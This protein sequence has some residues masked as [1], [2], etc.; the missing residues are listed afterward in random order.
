MPDQPAEKQRERAQPQPTDSWDC[1][2]SSN[3]LTLA[4]A[5]AGPEPDLGDDNARAGR[6][7]PT[8][9]PHEKSV[10]ATTLIA[11]ISKMIAETTAAGSTR[12]LG[13]IT[14]EN[15]FDASAKRCPLLFVSLSHVAKMR[16]GFAT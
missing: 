8:L 2:Q 12:S 1:Q 13:Q 3:L 5:Q 10:A 11:D 15:D 7:S 4:S 6:C 14:N 9:P 16:Q